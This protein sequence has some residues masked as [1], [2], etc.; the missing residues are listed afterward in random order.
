M[1]RRTVSGR[2]NAPANALWKHALV[3]SFI[4]CISVP[5]YIP[6][7]Q[8]ALMA[9]AANAVAYFFVQCMETGVVQRVSLSECAPIEDL[10]A[11]VAKKFRLRRQEIY[12]LAIRGIII[13]MDK[14]VTVGD[15]QNKA[16]LAAQGGKVLHP[17]EVL[18]LVVRRL[19]Y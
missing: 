5:T 15:V 9:S 16:M 7:S 2:T 18:H 10:F 12:Q 13:D 1:L 8:H 6:K 3:H 19:E 4:P 17:A 11:R 14:F